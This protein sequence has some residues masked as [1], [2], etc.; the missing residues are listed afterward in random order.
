MAWGPLEPSRRTKGRQAAGGSASATAPTSCEGAEK[1]GREGDPP[2]GHVLCPWMV[3]GWC[4]AWI[5]GTSASSMGRS[6]HG[7]RAPD[8]CGLEVVCTEGRGRAI[9]FGVGSARK[10]HC[11]TLWGA[12]P[13]CP[14]RSVIWEFLRCT[15]CFPAPTSFTCWCR[16]VRAA[17]GDG[18]PVQPRRGPIVARRPDRLCR[19]APARRPDAPT[20]SEWHEPTQHDPRSELRP[21]HSHPGARGKEQREHYDE[22]YDE[23]ST[24]RSPV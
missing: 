21:P 4:R 1:T 19:M 6:W 12:S 14:S 17:T 2:S 3:V 15:H 9:E 5:I 16:P 23:S 11:Y 13:R 20:L 22:H 7:P 8:I 10:S 24:E 18:R